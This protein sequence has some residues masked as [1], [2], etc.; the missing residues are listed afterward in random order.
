MAWIDIISPD[1]ATGE[2][3]KQYDEAIGRA[4][5]LWNIVSIM[6]QNPAVM[7]ASMTHYKAIM[8]GDSDLTRTQREMLAVVVSAENHCV[9]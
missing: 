1:A 7:K 9:Y 3:K 4:G 5:R 2:L 6:S 8:F